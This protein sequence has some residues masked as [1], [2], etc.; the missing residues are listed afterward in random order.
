M[1][2]Q[3]DLK[4]CPFCGCDMGTL[5]IR[6][7]YRWF[8]RH[9]LTCPISD[10]PSHGYGKRESMLEEWNKRADT[11]L[12]KPASKRKPDPGGYHNTY[13]K[14]EFK[15]R[16]KIGA[17]I[18]QDMA[19]F[20]WPDCKPPIKE[21]DSWKVYK[22]RTLF[23][24]RIFDIVK[25]KEGFVCSADGYGQHENGPKGYGNGPIHIKDLTDIEIVEEK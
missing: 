23:P 18:F 3:S 7:F 24:D 20:T 9:T 8:G 25:S 2:T 15:G 13:D 19:S 12:V 5:E 21:Y 14:K 16:I 1:T 11:K 6:G 17:A 10:N 4:P 22:C